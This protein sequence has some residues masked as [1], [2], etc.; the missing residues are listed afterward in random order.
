MSTVYDA[1]V[2]GSGGFLGSAIVAGLTSRSARVTGFTRQDPVLVDDALSPRA[3][4]VPVIVWAAGGITPTVA[5]E[6]PDAVAAELGAFRAF[7]AAAAARPAPPRIVLLSSGGAVYGRPAVP[8]YAETD[9]PAPP[10]AY[11]AYKLAQ[12]R[13]LAA[14][15]LPATVMRI[16]NAYGPGQ[17]GAHG[18]GVLAIWMR[19]IRAGEAIALHGDGAVAR[20]YV[21]AD[22]V[23]DA[24]ARIV[25][26]PQPPPV[27]NVGSGTPTSLAALLELLGDAVGPDRMRV[28]RRPSRGV[29]P[30]ST[31]LDI[32][33]ARE[34][35][36]WEPRVPL[37]A[38]IADMWERQ[39]R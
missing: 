11:G 26:A 6:D 22:D 33:L 30:D 31:W 5:A 3:A 1:A 9:A 37:A 28:D 15:G 19:A 29:D 13:V 7:A 18:Q 24:V 12:E 36:G 16:A 14:A 27:V 34:A 35:L 32:A 17:R 23:V 21:H 39:P 2:V 38:G 20:D 8:P 10:N 25:D 4:D